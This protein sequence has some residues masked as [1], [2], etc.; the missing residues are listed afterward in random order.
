MS[1]KLRLAWETK[2]GNVSLRI[3][4]GALNLASKSNTFPFIT[5]FLCGIPLS[6]KTKH[7]AC[8]LLHREP[9]GQEVSLLPS[10]WH[11]VLYNSVHRGPA[12]HSSVINKWATV[13]AKPERPSLSCHHT[14]FHM[15]T[16]SVHRH[17]GWLGAH[18]T[19]GNTSHLSFDNWRTFDNG[20]QLRTAKNAEF[21]SFVVTRDTRK[22]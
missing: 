3:C 2:D 13:Q 7:E 10:R 19:R 5:L 21:H 12:S 17:E 18:R 6:R 11:W 15:H 16:G 4:R 9:R 14:C 8:L 22:E 20:L 1:V